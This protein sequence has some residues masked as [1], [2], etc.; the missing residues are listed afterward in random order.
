MAHD[1]KRGEV[2][3]GWHFELRAD[4]SVHVRKTVAG[5]F[6]TIVTH[7]TFTAAEWDELV[8]AMATPEVE[9][10]T[11]AAGVKFD[12]AVAAAAAE[13]FEGPPEPTP[14]PPA[15]EELEP[16]PEA[17]DTEPLPEDL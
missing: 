6:D 9:P 17:L 11:F 5:W 12:A 13:E 3:T 16:T 1:V 7:E 2:S 15:D 10:K 8:L 14:M 4:G